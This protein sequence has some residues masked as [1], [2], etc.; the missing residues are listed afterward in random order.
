[1]PS[2]G[3]NLLNLID[4]AQ[5]DV[6]LVAPFMKAEVVAR[7]IHTI[8]PGVQISCI[9]RW[10]PLEIKAGVN[11]LEI[12]D[13]LQSR[14]NAKLLLV[15][16]LHAKFYRADNRYAVGSANLTKMALGWAPNPNIEL[17]ITGNMDTRLREWESCLLSQGIEVDDALVRYFKRL[18]EELPMSEF[19]L[20]EHSLDAE[21]SVPFDSETSG[22]AIH[23]WLPVL[24]YPEL[25][26]DVYSGNLNEISEGAK[27]AAM[28]DLVALS[29]PRGLDKTRF[30]AEVAAALLQMPLVRRVDQYLSQS[31]RFGAVRDFLESSE[32]YPDGS[33]PTTDWQNLMRWF[34]HFLPSRFRRVVPHYSEVM[35]RID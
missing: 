4:D 27:E 23:S 12:W 31:R 24:R 17:L 26:H 5:S 32:G 8:A 29:I 15:S 33:N 21:E 7:I 25:L 19:I 30:E 18:V 22:P 35:Y 14:E 20:T 13:V 10:R 28:H 3:D 9:T 34:L 2:I 16:S 1:M 11:D 6:I